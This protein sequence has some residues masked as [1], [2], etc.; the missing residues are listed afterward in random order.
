[1]AATF[2]NCEIF[3]TYYFSY[4]RDYKAALWGGNHYVNT[5]GIKWRYISKMQNQEIKKMRN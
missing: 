5:T 1:M 2:E 4:E 3:S